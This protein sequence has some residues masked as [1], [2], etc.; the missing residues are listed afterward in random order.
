MNF[1]AKGIH[2]DYGKDGIISFALH[3]GIVDTVT[4]VAVTRAIGKESAMAADNSARQV[5]KIIENSGG[6]HSGRF[7]AYDGRELKW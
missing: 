5:L 1:I 7:W 6:E 2:I 4:G 3:P